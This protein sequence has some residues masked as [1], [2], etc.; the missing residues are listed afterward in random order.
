[1]QRLDRDE[2]G[3][4]ELFWSAFKL[5]GRCLESLDKVLKVAHSAFAVDLEQLSDTIAKLGVFDGSDSTLSSNG[6]RTNAGVRSADRVSNTGEQSKHSDATSPSVDLG[7]PVV[8]SADWVAKCRDDLWAVEGWTAAAS[9]QLSLA[10]TEV[11]C[12]TKVKELELQRIGANENVFR[13]DVAMADLQGMMDG[14][15]C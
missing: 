5:V 6:H 3:A 15:D 13:F 8:H 10:A 2:G 12:Q 1:M 14:V 11:S 4:L 7:S 9:G